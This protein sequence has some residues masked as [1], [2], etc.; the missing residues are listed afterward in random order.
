MIRISIWALLMAQTATVGAAPPPK[1][2]ATFRDCPHC[3][4]MIVLPAGRFAM[5]STVE[6]RDREGVLPLFGD[7]EGPVHEVIIARP[8]AMSRTEIRR[9]EFLKFARATHRASPVDCQTYDPVRDSWV[10]G[11]HPSSWQE[12]EIPIGDD[13]PAVCMTWTDAT[14]YAAWLSKTTGHH[15]RVPSDAEWEY[16]ARGRTSTARYW[17]NALQP[18]CTKLNIMSDATVAAIGRPK[19]WADVLVCRSDH[20]WTVPVAG[21]PANPF[22]LYDMLGS[23][24]E[25]TAD[26]SHPDYKGAPV[27]G[28]AW[29]EPGCSKHGLRGGAFHS[30]YWLAR[31]AT[32]GKGMAPDF[33]PLAAGIRVVREM[34]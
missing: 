2:S 8:F 27:D 11:P 10:D 25:W 14:D 24:W 21:Y 7:R 26:C 30:Q 17:G 18:I 1:A 28:S 16:A 19:S 13:H 5:G 23:V 22:G 4:E 3:P 29:I 12:P 6:E 20:A 15:Y 9:V 34:D 33:R 32:R 31:A